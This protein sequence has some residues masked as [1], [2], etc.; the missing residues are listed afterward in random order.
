MQKEEYVQDG[1][2]PAT[3]QVAICCMIRLLQAA[4]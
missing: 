3:K 2:S 1:V 4:E